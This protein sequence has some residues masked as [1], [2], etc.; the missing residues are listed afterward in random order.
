MRKSSA[1]VK[2]VTSSDVVVRTLIFPVLTFAPVSNT[3]TTPIV[4]DGELWHTS[5][6]IAN[7]SWGNSHSLRPGAWVVDVVNLEVVRVQEVSLGQTQDLQFG[8]RLQRHGS[9]SIKV[10]CHIPSTVAVVR[11]ISDGN[12]SLWEVHHL[13]MES[14][15]LVWTSVDG[16]WV[17]W[18]GWSIRGSRS[19]WNHWS[20][21]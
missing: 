15:L 13:S 7:R 20:T 21:R 9:H 18:T 2:V 5:F 19:T 1:L 8:Q 14:E 3:S 6:I 10:D 17:T 12:S 16:I 4:L 11:W